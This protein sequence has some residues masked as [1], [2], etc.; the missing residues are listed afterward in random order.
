[1][2]AF[3]P[4]PLTAGHHEALL[5]LAC[6][7]I[8]VAC[9]VHSVQC[10]VGPGRSSAHGVAQLVAVTT[11]DFSV[12]AD[13]N[14]TDIDNSLPGTLGVHNRKLL[15]TCPAPSS[16]TPTFVTIPVGSI[17]SFSYNDMNE[18]GFSVTQQVIAFRFRET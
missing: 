1:M 16:N 13:S 2:Q 4:F 10:Q 14:D 15:T 11:E 6:F 8:A 3:T 12:L 17:T 7:A 18:V 5:R 9:A